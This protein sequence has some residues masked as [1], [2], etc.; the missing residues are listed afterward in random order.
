MKADIEIGKHMKGLI[1]WSLIKRD[2][3]EMKKVF[4][5]IVDDKPDLMKT[6]KSF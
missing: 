4:F 5:N 2:F 6:W 3:K 1:R